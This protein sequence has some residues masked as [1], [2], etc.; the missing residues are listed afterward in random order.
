MT[1]LRLPESDSQTSREGTRGFVGASYHGEKPALK[2]TRHSP[3]NNT[4]VFYM[5]LHRSVGPGPYSR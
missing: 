2:P 4:S 3:V 1:L 5:T